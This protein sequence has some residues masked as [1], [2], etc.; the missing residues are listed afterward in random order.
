VTQLPP[1]QQPRVRA[2]RTARAG[3]AFEVRC[4]LEHPME[5]GLRLEGGRAVPRDLVGRLVV[6]VNG[7][8]A[9]DATLRNGTAANP[10]HV[11]VLRA[12]PERGG[13]AE[14]D[15]AW[16]DEAGRTAR[17]TARVNVTA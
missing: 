9:V 10:Y 2:P 15:F 7:E 8:V 5:T 4:L 16:T 11:F 12:P 13:A 17:A 3:E 6:R 14:L 1:L